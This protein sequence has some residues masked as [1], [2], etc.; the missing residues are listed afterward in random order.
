MVSYCYVSISGCDSTVFWSSQLVWSLYIHGPCLCLHYCKQSGLFCD[1]DS[2]ILESKKTQLNSF[3]VTTVLP[4]VLDFLSFK[5]S[6]VWTQE[7]LSQERQRSEPDHINQ[8]IAWLSFL[9]MQH[10][11]FCLLLTV[12][13]IIYITKHLN[14]AIF[15]VSMNLISCR[16]WLEAGS[17]ASFIFKLK[18]LITFW[19]PL[20]IQMWENPPVWHEPAL[21]SIFCQ[22]VRVKLV[23]LSEL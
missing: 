2:S 17:I 16:C 20:Y 18:V 10:M 14:T 15:S 8:H 19:H 5:T 3:Q 4:F 23:Q 9:H 7:S 22:V 6:G 11:Y 21:W 1:T 12:V 13:W